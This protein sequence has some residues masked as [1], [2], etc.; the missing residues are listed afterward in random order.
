MLRFQSQNLRDQLPQ[1]NK[2]KKE[3]NQKIVT[4]NFKKQ[5]LK[6]RLKV[7]QLEIVQFNK[8]LHHSLIQLN[9]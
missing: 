8:K 6:I 2:N 1:K 9:N 4:F 7:R 3:M 5:I